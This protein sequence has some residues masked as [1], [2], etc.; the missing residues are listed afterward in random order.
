MFTRAEQYTNFRD[1]MVFI[2]YHGINNYNG[3]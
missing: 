3:I 1:G 2:K